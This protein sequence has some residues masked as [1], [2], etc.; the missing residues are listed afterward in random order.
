MKE[1]GRHVPESTSAEVL[2]GTA[3]KRA[4]W[5]ACWTAQEPAATQAGSGSQFRFSASR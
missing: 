5:Q 1:P 4:D 2:R 3:A